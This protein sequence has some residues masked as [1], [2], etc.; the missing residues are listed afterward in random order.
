MTVGLLKAIISIVLT[1]IS[2]ETLER[3]KRLL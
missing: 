2:S 3:K 1:A